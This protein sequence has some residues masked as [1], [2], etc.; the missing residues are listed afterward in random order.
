VVP[1][2][3]R[4]AQAHAPEID[5]FDGLLCL[6]RLA[7]E[8]RA[9]ARD[10]AAAVAGEFGAALR[11]ALGGTE[12]PGPTAALWVAAAR[13]RAPYT[14][15]PAVAARHPGLGPAAGLAVRYSAR[16]AKQTRP[17]A[18]RPETHL[19]V[20]WAP[21]MKV[22]RRADLPTVLMHVQ[23]FRWDGSALSSSW[24][25]SLWPSGHEAFFA[26]EANQLATFLESQGSYW[27]GDWE[28]VF[29]PDEGLGPMAR[30]LIVLA[31]TARHPAAAGLGRD[32]L[33]AAIEDGRLDGEGL[34]QPMTLLLP[35]DVVAHSRW[36]AA[37]RDAARVSP[38][39]M[40]VLRDALEAAA[41]ALPASPAN[42]LVPFLELLLEWS[43]ETGAAISREDARARLKD[44]SGS[45]KAA[46]LARSL[47]GLARQPQNPVRRAA[48]LRTLESRL[49]RA[50]RYDGITARSRAQPARP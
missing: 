23:D 9:E 14:D 13:A 10:S 7:R 26:S 17:F 4:A 22:E 19:R 35:S 5:V 48:G 21:E 37:F 15:D 12:V 8:G 28:P 1:D 43:V 29:D 2:R 6:L 49:K 40:V 34:A 11:Y 42:R 44:V 41:P 25:A 45:G 30:L 39:H 31:L 3:W 24:E 46:K 20:E 36:V 27:Q 33:I 38:L 47:I 32:A 50:E 18:A 16:I